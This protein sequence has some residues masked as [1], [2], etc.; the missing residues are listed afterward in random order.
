MRRPVTTR[1]VGSYEELTSVEEPVST[2][3]ELATRIEHHDG[4]VEILIQRTTPEWPWEARITARSGSREF[5]GEMWS[6]EWDGRYQLNAELW[7]SPDDDKYL[8]L[9]TCWS[10]EEEAVFFKIELYEEDDE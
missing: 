3:I 4:R 1:L 5:T 10:D 7:V 2:D 9:G 8:L 6:S